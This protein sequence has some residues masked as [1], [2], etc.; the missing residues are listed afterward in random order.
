MSI[1]PFS[2]NALFIRN[3]KERMRPHMA[4]SAACVALIVIFFI[5]IGNY[6]NRDALD[7]YDYAQKK[8]IPVPWLNYAFFYLAVMQGVILFLF[9]CISVTRMA[10]QEKISGTLDFHRCSPLERI[11]QIIGLVLGAASL[12]WC[13]FLG[14][15]AI[16]AVVMVMA[17]IDGVKCLIFYLSMIISALFIHSLSALCALYTNPRRYRAGSVVILIYLMSSMAFMLSCVYHATP[18]PAY[19]DLYNLLIQQNIASS[20]WEH[21]HSLMMRSF[22]GYPMHYFL[23]QALIQVPLLILFL[24]GIKRRFEYGE[25]PVWSKIESV[26]F[27][28]LALFYLS[29]SISQIGY[30][31]Y[32]IPFNAQLIF[33][34]FAVFFLMLMA[35]P[36][37]TPTQLAFLKGL[38][39]ARKTGCQRLSPND[40]RSSNSLW[41]T[42]F[43]C[44]IAAMFVMIVSFNLHIASLYEL[45]KILFAGLC[46]VIFF[47]GILEYFN[48]SKY[49]QKKAL[50]IVGIIILWFLIPIFGYIT[51]VRA[52]NVKYLQYFLAPSPLFGMPMLTSII[53]DHPGR[54]AADL[55][56]YVFI[57]V[58]AVMAVLALLL[59][60][61]E[62]LR[63]TSTINSTV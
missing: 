44:S 61:A 24:I 7:Y 34:W 49:H 22:F 63:L 56:P 48:L 18:F 57:I 9:G 26:V 11:N 17:Q 10:G 36:P 14:T 33:F 46:H 60:R 21:Q 4:G 31:P 8:S 50:L 1:R 32:A 15:M 35:A 29:G 45:V 16:S 40:D 42:A 37:A 55:E 20:A 2:D 39:R 62:R 41:I 52:S 43:C 19:T 27:V 58:S 53:D 6:I 28:S 23:L 47:C 25:R 13:L 59:A 54:Y 30:Y 12:E 5:F 51:N 3:W 38:R